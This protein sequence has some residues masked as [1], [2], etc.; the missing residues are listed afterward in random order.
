MVEEAQ[1]LLNAW[2]FALRMSGGDLKL[3]KSFWTLQD[4][5]WRNDKYHLLTH[6]PYQITVAA[7]N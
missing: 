1:A 6:I 7:D 5:E 2:Y 4:Y 3:E